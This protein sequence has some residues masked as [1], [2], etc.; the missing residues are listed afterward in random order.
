MKPNKKGLE[1]RYIILFI[2]G[3]IL[4]FVAIIWFT[5]LGAGMRESAAG[6]FNLFG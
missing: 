4:V 3:L 5:K 2:I 1:M 6:I